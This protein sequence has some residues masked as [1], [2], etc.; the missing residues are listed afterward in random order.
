MPASDFWK[1]S[2]ESIPTLKAILLEDA[3]A[4]TAPNIQMIEEHKLLYILGAKPGDHKFLFDQLEIS[5]KTTYHEITTNDGYYHQFRFLNRVSLNKSNQDLLVNVIE[6]RQTDPKGKETNFSWVTNIKLSKTNVLKIAKAGRARW[7]IENETF[8]TLKNLGYKFEHN[9]G[10]G[11]KYLAT[12][13]CM[14]MML[15]FLIDQVQEI[16]CSLFRRCKKKA[17]TNRNLWE[18]MRAL[19][20][21][22]PLN[23]WET[24]YKIIAKEQ[25]LDTS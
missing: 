17:G 25:L 2:A 13:F 10:H 6:Y 9:Y 23:N 5:K 14:L 3:L 4:S 20:Q 21:L 15:A 24:L 11:E 7:K 8:N 22:M 12:I 19:F 18:N 1:I 16:S